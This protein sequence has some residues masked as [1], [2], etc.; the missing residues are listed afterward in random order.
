MVRC[1]RGRHAWAVSSFPFCEH[2][3]VI[4]AACWTSRK[5]SDFLFVE[6]CSLFGKLQSTDCGTDSGRC[7]VL[8]LMAVD[9]QREGVVNW[10]SLF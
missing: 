1:L 8:V 10:I 4:M 2:L 3:V 5:A 6:Y 9:A 7:S